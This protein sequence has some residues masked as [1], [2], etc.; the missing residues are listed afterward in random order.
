MV[1]AISE[2][3]QVGGSLMVAIPKSVR[4]AMA[5]R[6]NQMV[7]IDVREFKPDFFGKFKGIGTIGAEDKLDTEL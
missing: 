4:K 3:R 6:K 5:L 1:T 7:E 2:T